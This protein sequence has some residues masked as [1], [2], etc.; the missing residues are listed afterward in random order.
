MKL[1]SNKAIIKNLKQ[2][3][4]EAAAQTK[5][6]KEQTARLIEAKFSRAV[7]EFKN[8]ATFKKEVTEHRHTAMSM[9]LMIAKPKSKISSQA[10]TL[11][12]SFFKRRKKERKKKKSRKVRFMRNTLKKKL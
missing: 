2:K 5:K 10:W 4:D 6:I 12:K 3:L 9:A 7:Y 1:L 8:S 11:R